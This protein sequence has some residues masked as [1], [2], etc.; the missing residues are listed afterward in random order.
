M[1]QRIQSVIQPQVIPGKATTSTFLNVYQDDESGAIYFGSRT[2]R[3]LRNAVKKGENNV[4]GTYIKT[5]E[6]KE[7]IEL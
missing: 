6:V 2:F 7:E 4:G 1:S 3:Q 5:V